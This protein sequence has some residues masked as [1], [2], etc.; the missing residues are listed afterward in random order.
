MTK[1]TSKT[2]KTIAFPSRPVDG[3]IHTIRDQRVMLD[4]DLAELYDV[5][6]KF[7]NLAVR[8]NPS[9]FP[10]DFMFQLTEQETDSLR[11]QIA[12][13]KIGRGGRRYLP[14]VFTEPGVAM[15]SSVLRSERAVQINILIMRAFIRLRELVAMN[16]DI[17]ARIAKLEQGHD[18]TA[19]IIE[20]LLEDIDKLGQKL[21]QFQSPPSPYNRRRIGYITDDEGSK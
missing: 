15:L 13:S 2:S 1:K 17:A 9:R 7:I 20:I 4:S 5:P 6:T 16:K 3:L 21:E 11:L 12:T 19:S 14:H 18:R 10:L 8:R